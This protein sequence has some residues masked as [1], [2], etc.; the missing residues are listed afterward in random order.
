LGAAE[1]DSGDLATQHGKD[2]TGIVLTESK[3]LEVANRLEAARREDAGRRNQA[4]AASRFIGS[5]CRVGLG[6]CTN[7]ENKLK[8]PVISLLMQ[9]RSLQ[10]IIR[11]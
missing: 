8:P 10:V 11:C 6:N 7:V 2:K 5:S 3:A 9:G 1:K 4:E